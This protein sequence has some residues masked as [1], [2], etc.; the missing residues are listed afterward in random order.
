MM[1]LHAS[2]SHLFHLEYNGL[3]MNR[4]PTQTA[5]S[6]LLAEHN[7][8]LLQSW[9]WGEFKQ[10]FGWST[11]RLQ[12]GQAAAQILFRKLPLGFTLAYIPKGPMVDWHNP[13]EWRSLLEAAHTLARQKRAVFL[14]I[15]PDVWLPEGQEVASENSPHPQ[16]LSRGERGVEVRQLTEAGFTPADP[17]QPQTSVL[18]DL[19]GD[20]DTIL[21]AMKQ[22]TRY[23][24]RLAERKGVTVRQGDEA[25]IETFYAL[26]QLTAARDGFGVHR[27]AYYRTV[28]TLFGP[29][30][31]ALLLTEFEGEAL[32]GLMVFRQ[33]RE[34]CYF[35]GASSNSQRNLMPT[36]LLQWAAMRW[37]KQQGCTRYDL[38]GI[39]HAPAE[40][41]EAE[42]DRRTDGLWGVYRFKRG[43]GGSIVHSPGA[44][45]FVYNPLLY[46]LYRLRRG[47]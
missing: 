26:S 29:E 30:Q 8:H 40:T 37:A 33:G 10:Q 47:V 6:Q 32:A 27:L 24:I 22:K 20:E 35:Y 41:L 45:D 5:W 3:M 9:A 34:A 46:R 4:S 36:Y 38:W 43:F 23:N 44:F 17:S 15:E 7:G 21:A 1:P 39:P 18:V 25:D 42:F 14:K 11:E 31:C 13:A 28:F 16:P 2:I 12:V 19:S